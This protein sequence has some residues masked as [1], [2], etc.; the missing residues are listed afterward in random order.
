MAPSSNLAPGF[1]KIDSLEAG[2]VVAQVGEEGAKPYM[3]LKFPASGIPM[4]ASAP[5]FKDPYGLIA[6]YYF[7]K[8][9]PVIQQ[10]TQV[11]IVLSSYNLQLLGVQ[12]VKNQRVRVDAKVSGICFFSL[13]GAQIS[14]QDPN[15][16][17][18]ASGLLA[19]L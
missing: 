10:G 17:E 2:T 7:D 1:M 5:Y 6:T 9:F 12:R 19:L 3:G 16:A 11:L 15:Y 13:Y 4:H 8:L 14:N 18:L